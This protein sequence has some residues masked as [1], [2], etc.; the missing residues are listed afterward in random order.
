VP[1]LR[2]QQVWWR[3]LGVSPTEEQ[4]PILTDPSRFILV[5]GGE[6]GGKSFTGHLYATPR[7][8]DSKLIW[9]V[10]ADYRMSIAEFN[11]MY[12]ALDSLGAIANASIP[13]N[14]Y[15]PRSFRTKWG[16][17]VRTVTG[18][19]EERIGMMAPDGIIGAEAARLTYSMYLRLRARVAETRGWVFLE[20]TFENAQDWYADLWEEWQSGTEHG[21]KSFSLPSWSNRV[22]FPGGVDDPEI[23]ALRA[24]LGDVRFFERHG[25]IPSPPSGA[26]FPEFRRPTHV[27]TFPFNPERPVE[28]TI[29]PGWAGA[30]AVVALQWD[31]ASVYAIDT[32]YEQGKGAREIIAQVRERPWWENVNPRRAGVIDIAGK[33]H[34]GMES[35]V[36]IWASHPSEGGAGVFLSSGYVPIEDGIERYRT[37]LRDPVTGN[38]RLFYN[39][40]TCE[41]AI[42]EHKLYRYPD[43]KPSKAVREKPVDR[44]NHAIKAMTYWLVRRYGLVAAR[45]LS[46]KPARFGKVQDGRNGPFGPYPGTPA[47]RHAG[48]V[49]SRRD[50]YLRRTAASVGRRTRFG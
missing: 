36:D 33:Q 35:H 13:E 46:S 9:I 4:I 44:D 14:E 38:A 3:Y 20:G 19:K 29:D 10:A 12:Q 27:G 30:Y 39:A 31:N 21:E 37:F 5:A 25:G 42:K 22:I 41:P 7:T 34:Q 6:R 28:I 2:E 23:Q 49:P 50:E 8:V 48:V 17:E 45:P 43:D 15:Q 24:R 47:K 18:Q 40:D 16:C 1:S 32:V 11:Y 26:V